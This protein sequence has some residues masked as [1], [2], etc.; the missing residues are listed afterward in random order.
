MAGYHAG[1]ALALEALARSGVPAKPDPALFRRW[2]PADLHRFAAHFLR[3]RFPILLALNKS[4]L[5]SAAAALPA[6]RAAFP[7]E[8]ALA[9]SA[10]TEYQL[11][12]LR[13]DGLVDYAAGGRHVT[14]CEPGAGSDHL[15]NT[16][17]TPASVV[18]VRETMRRLGGTTG[19]QVRPLC[20][21]L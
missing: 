17:R 3:L 18:A 16:A 10:S 4:D 9:L 13:R 8:P 7:A 14:E 6:V 20:S 12:R 2:L 19:V 5:P 21:L 1:R 15:L 11:C